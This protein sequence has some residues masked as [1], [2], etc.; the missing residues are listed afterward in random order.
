MHK[1]QLHLSV[2]WCTDI[3]TH[4]LV[5]LSSG[6]KV[7]YENQTDTQVHV[8]MIIF[9]TSLFRVQNIL[10]F[11]DFQII[12]IAVKYYVRTSMSL[13][14]SNIAV[15]ITKTGTDEKLYVV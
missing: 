15:S 10:I 13:Y 5:F 8:N 3:H 14:C 4:N 6:G 11:Y 7:F 1:R 9:F 2:Q 12:H